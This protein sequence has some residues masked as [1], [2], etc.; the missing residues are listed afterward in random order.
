MSEKIYTTGIQNF[1]KTQH[2]SDKRKILKS[3]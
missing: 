2:Q 1:E 3:V